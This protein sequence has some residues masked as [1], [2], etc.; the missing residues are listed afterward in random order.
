MFESIKNS[1]I[2]WRKRKSEA[3]IIK[4]HKKCLL[5][6][7]QEKQFKELQ[8]WRMKNNKASF[9]RYERGHPA[10]CAGCDN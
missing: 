8:T 5:K 9:P 3:K 1:L 10:Y 4:I 2:A 6:V 7:E